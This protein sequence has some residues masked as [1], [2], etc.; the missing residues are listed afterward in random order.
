MS[1]LKALRDEKP[2]LFL[3][4]MA[5]LTHGGFRR[6]IDQQGGC[7][8]FFGEM[9]SAAGLCNQGANERYYL[10][11]APDYGRSIAQ[12]LGHRSDL[13]IRS[14]A[15]LVD[16]GF[17]H[18]DLNMGCSAPDMLKKG[19]GAALL[20]QPELLYGLVANIRESLPPHITLSGKIRLG[21]KMDIPFLR[22]LGQSLEAAGLDF[23][24]LHP[25]TIRQKPSRPPFWD[26]LPQLSESVRI[27]V[28]GNGGITSVESWS[29]ARERTGIQHWMIGRAAVEKPWIFRQLKGGQEKTEKVNLR[30][31][32][33]DFFQ[34][35][36]EHQPEEFHFSRAK[37]FSLYFHR[38]LTF[39]YQ[40]HY[41]LAQKTKNAQKI[42]KAYLEY[43]QRNP[44]EG[45]KNFK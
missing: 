12:L 40:L 42:K 5:E 32:L 18:L 24:T 16:K 13:L 4:P 38:N 28:I 2:L 36:E 11:P 17:K 29:R 27:P 8:Y 23:L 14:A 7:D 3:A 39:G 45:L 44:Q 9:I 22:D 6:L 10:D 25:K 26:M 1:L 15:M 30:Q 19:D 37:R 21:D 31:I 41:G 33:M 43:F 34:L 20:R 35:L